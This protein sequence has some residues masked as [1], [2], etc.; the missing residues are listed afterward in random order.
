M[1]E[2]PQGVT[3]Q[4]AHKQKLANIERSST[5]LREV[6]E[7]LRHGS[8][9]DAAVALSRIRQAEDVD[10]AIIVLALAQALVTHTSSNSGTSSGSPPH[11]DEDAHTHLPRSLSHD[12]VGSSLPNGS[13]EH[14]TLKQNRVGH[15]D[16]TS[17]Q[18]AT[19]TRDRHNEDAPI[20]L[21]TLT[22][23]ISKWTQACKDDRLLNHLLT[24]FWT[25]DNTVEQSLF[26]PLFEEELCNNDP[27]AGGL[28]SHAFCSPFLVNALLALSCVSTY[29][30]WSVV[31]ALP[32]SC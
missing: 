1:Y 27:Q 2:A 17:G 9:D 11:T 16:Y 26:R 24:L 25:W 4:Q 32:R 8:E 20:D 31:L 14:Q 21:P 19:Q 23:P 18:G 28:D 6:V 10:E 7:L 3:R 30:P 22:L 5:S 13:T 15:T 12:S 29:T